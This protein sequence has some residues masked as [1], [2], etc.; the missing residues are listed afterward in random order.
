M[1]Q[2]FSYGGTFS[3]LGDGRMKKAM[4]KAKPACNS[5]IVVLFLDGCHCQYAITH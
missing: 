5:T 4:A 2:M 1:T 3:E